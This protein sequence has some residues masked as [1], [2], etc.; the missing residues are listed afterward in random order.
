MNI[1]LETV[2]NFSEG[3][4]LAIVEQ[5]AD[6]F[7]GKEGVK[8]LDYSSD[9]D[10]NRSVFTVI[11][12][13][14]SLRDAVI[15]SAKAALD[16]I[17]LRKHKGQHP[18]MGCVDV[19]PF[20]PIKGCDL[21]DADK[22]AREV[23]EALGQMGQPVFLYERSASRPNRE[24]LSDIRRGEFEGMAE[25]MKGEDW[26]PDFGPQT[27]H[28]SGGVTAVG[29]RM[30]LIAFNVNLNTPDLNIAKA[31]AKVVRHSGG[32]LRYVKAMGVML[33]DRNLAQVSMNLTDYTQTSVY[34]VFEMVKSE[35]RRYGVSIA[36]SELI[37]LTPVKALVDSAEYYL[38]MEQFSFDQVLEMRL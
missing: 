17:D 1:I 35:A 28:P 15:A 10:H 37:G 31:I 33:E 14:G 2:P 27:I 11:G 23:G 19:I 26:V 21:K 16:L 7:R 20:I 34:R 4:D 22:V 30:P 6:C 3:R 32:G 8:L 36:G 24:N 29:A 13:P 38:K 12:E 25:K 9:K 5:I 18:R